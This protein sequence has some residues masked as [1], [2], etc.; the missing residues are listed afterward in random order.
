[1]SAP[2]EV[3]HVV[4]RSKLAAWK[5]LKDGVPRAVSCAD[6]RTMAVKTARRL[7]RRA[8]VGHLVIH[9]KDG[10]IEKNVTYRHPPPNGPHCCLP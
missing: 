6:S 9:K 8:S 4:F 10:S 5:V 7:A 1:M 2:C 3:F